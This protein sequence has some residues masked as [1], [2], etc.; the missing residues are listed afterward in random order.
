M[1]ATTKR[2]TESLVQKLRRHSARRLDEFLVRRHEL[3]HG[4]HVSFDQAKAILHHRLGW[5]ELLADDRF[6]ALVGGD[7]DERG[8]LRFLPWDE[9]TPVALALVN[10]EPHGR[11]FHQ[12]DGRLGRH[13]HGNR[14][15]CP[16]A[17][18]SSVVRVGVERVLERDAPLR[19]GKSNR[20]TAHGCFGT[21]HG[22]WDRSPALWRAS[23]NGRHGC[24]GHTLR[25]V[26]KSAQGQHKVHSRGDPRLDAVLDFLAFTAK[27]MPLVALLDEAPRRVASM[28]DA[29]VCSLY[30]VEGSEGELVM[31][32]NV[33]FGSAAIG[34]VRL[35]VGEGIT[36][37]AV[38][39]MRP[40][41]MAVAES[42]EAYKHFDDLGEERFPVFLAVPIRG[43]SGPLGALVIQRSE[44]PF[45]SHDIELLSAIGGLIAAG[46]RNAELVDEV[47]GKRPRHAGG[48]TRKVTLTG[49]PARPG[50]A[51]GA[52]A[53]LA[54]PPTHPV[55]A[56]LVTNA[57]AEVQ[58]LKNAFDVAERSIVA[59]QQRA[60]NLGLAKAEFLSTYGAILEDTRLRQRAMELVASGADVAQ[61]L[62]RVSRDAVR[63]AVSFSR[64]A[65]LK[66]RA[67]DIEELCDALRMLAKAD[68]RATLPSK[69][70]LVGDSLT[71]FDLLIS[72]RSQPVAVVLSE[73]A[74]NPRTR[75][76]I[77]L[78][79]LPAVV[80]VEGL[81]RWASDGDVALV[82]GGHGLFVIN[83]SKSEMAIVREQ[84][85][86]TA[87]TEGP[88][89]AEPR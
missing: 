33:G 38:E 48:G 68:R 14:T 42:H 85:K 82:D 89:D 22:G 23:R 70:V 3:H 40:I 17:P 10:V 80:D 1:S 34:D 28:L 35:R 25:S 19:A 13:N 2:S 62:S 55:A 37:N 45:N 5:V 16:L 67:Q 8:L 63:A 79:G 9:T 49:R 18:G 46:I 73:R 29:E 77:E 74:S 76:L 56:G 11:V 30:L 71:V 69:A 58:L 12:A 87:S 60:R 88:S 57:A 24:N 83:P 36:G 53:A 15:V 84:R 39:Y 52:V 59:L 41:S 61:A 7:D 65:F 27:D 86:E 26:A 66:E 4:R 6:P 75:V 72:A 81:F 31:R 44:R 20:L 78:L 47:R 43:K 64:D 32:G 50:L 51:V 21:C 54:R